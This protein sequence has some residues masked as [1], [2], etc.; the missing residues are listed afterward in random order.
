MRVL[1][2]DDLGF[3]KKGG[4]LYMVYQQQKEALAAR[5]R[6]GQASSLGLGSLP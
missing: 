5:S 2:V 4:S 1:S 3:G 6:K